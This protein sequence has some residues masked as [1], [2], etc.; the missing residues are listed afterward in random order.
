[1]KPS[2]VSQL[3]MMLMAAFP[4]S[5]TSDSTSAVYEQMLLDLDETLARRAVTRIIATAKWL[6]TIAEIRAASTELRLGP[7]R[8]GGEGWKD[9]M[10]AV[11][12]VGRYGVPKV[13][14]PLV[15]EAL[16]LWGSWQSFCDSPEDDPGGRARFI[17]LYDALAR[18]QRD[19]EVSG[20]PLPAAERPRPRLVAPVVPLPLAAPAPEAP[21]A[22]APPVPLPVMPSL[23]RPRGPDPEYRRYTGDELQAALD[24][25]KAN[26]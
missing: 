20:I 1:M 17:E 26:P 7:V 23:P 6:P 24:A 16:R 15:R 22:P 5:K 25:R 13:R 12:Y 10:A 9:A 21:T 2:E 19:T 3:V 11:R 8:D 4:A 14:D 18:R